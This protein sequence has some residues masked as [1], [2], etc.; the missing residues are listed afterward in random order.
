MAQ[1]VSIHTSLN[2]VV[3]DA[4]KPGYYTKS[5]NEVLFAGDGSTT[6]GF[7][8]TLA[9]KK[10]VPGTLQL[11]TN[12]T[13]HART[14]GLDV[15]NFDGTGTITCSD[16]STLTI[17]YATGAVT[18]AL[19]NV[20][21]SGKY[22]T[23]AYTYDVVETAKTGNGSSTALSYTTT[24]PYIVPGSVVLTS[25]DTYPETYGA[26]VDNKDGTGTITGSNGTVVTVNYITGLIS[27]TL[28]AA[29]GNSKTLTVQYKYGNYRNVTVENNFASHLPGTK[30]EAYVTDNNIA[31]SKNLTYLVQVIVTEMQ[32][33][34]AT[35]G[36]L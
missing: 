24:K 14:Y 25:N 26:D 36:A 20:I 35:G 30:L 32:T 27:A 7:S 10:V 17:T 1:D 12:D 31:T 11:V 16:A 34:R 6:S 3:L 33:S 15:N 18:G 22:L 21:A 5:T 8:E 9:N 28:A 13:A 23:A 29:L 4:L 19:G 2:S